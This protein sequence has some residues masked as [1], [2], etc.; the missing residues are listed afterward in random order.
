MSTSQDGNSGSTEALVAP[1]PNVTTQGPALAGRRD[2]WI[3]RMARFGK[4]LLFV[5]F[6]IFTVFLS[7]VACLVLAWRWFWHGVRLL[8]GNIYD[9][10]VGLYSWLDYFSPDPPEMREEKFRTLRSRVV[11]IGTS[12]VPA[13]SL[14]TLGWD[15]IDVVLLLLLV[16]LVS[17]ALWHSSIVAANSGRR[18]IYAARGLQYEA[19][20]P[21]SA[22]TKAQIPT[23]QVAISIPGLLM[24]SHQGYGIRYGDYL[25][26]PA[27]VV[28]RFSEVV[29]STPYGKILISVRGVQSRLTD[30]LTYL[31]VGA[32]VFSRLRVVAARMPQRFIPGFGA[33]I[34]VSGMSSGRIFK[35]Q[36][37]GRL[38]FEGST[39]PGMSGA[40]YMMN[41]AFVGVHQ[42]ASGIANLGISCEVI[43]A[44]LPHLL[45]G[46]AVHGP[47]PGAE[48]AEKYVPKFQG[49]S[50][51]FDE[52]S[53]AAAK[54][55][56]QD[57]WCD[58][59]VAD[60]FYDQKLVFEKSPSVSNPSSITIKKND[61]SVVTVP[62]TNQ[63]KEG[64]ERTFDVVPSDLI[65]YLDELRAMGI[66]Q[67]C[68]EHRDRLDSLSR[69]EIEQDGEICVLKNR[70]AE[71][72]RAVADIRS[73]RQSA[74]K[75]EV[76]KMRFQCGQC[77]MSCRTDRGLTAHVA[78]SHKK[79]SVDCGRCGVTYRTQTTYD[80]H[81]V[82]GNCLR[83]ESAL[84][85]D[86]GSSGEVVGQTKKAFLGKKASQKNKQRP[87]SRSS[88]VRVGNSQSPLQEDVL[89]RI[90]ESQQNMQKCFEKFLQV[91]AG[92]SLDTTLN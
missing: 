13:V 30:D 21:G 2:F 72:E 65:D 45:K 35:S 64:A 22:F 17:V 1:V 9:N 6:A 48:G 16:V 61:G 69:R 44:E 92:Q 75:P 67:V 29:L 36:L 7:L 25:I 47:S 33:C 83:K 89:S 82:N 15:F 14:T 54:R 34:G 41:G 91:S 78:S 20:R 19:M 11:D 56:S 38:V 23:C 18:L 59:D 60:D 53:Q 87:S 31:F 63:N 50:W 52:L 42:G 88:Q 51:T 86:T 49:K 4:I 71:L 76:P 32:D 85:E 26:T 8:Q 37:R 46:E 73:K 12:S 62:I 80:H 55:Y 28:E 5:A 39:L 84:P 27:H 24:D 10:C 70:V 79:V 81:L 3:D 43:R 40:A 77:P 68:S 57:D 66:H 58:A 90:L 74:D